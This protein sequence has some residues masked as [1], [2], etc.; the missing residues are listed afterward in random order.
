[1]NKT[2]YKSDYGKVEIVE[3]EEVQG[4]YFKYENKRCFYVDVKCK[5]KDYGYFKTEEKAK[6]HAKKFC[7]KQMKYYE[8]LLSKL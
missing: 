5:S 6:E 4:N 8:D 7:L 2:Y 1:M 3:L